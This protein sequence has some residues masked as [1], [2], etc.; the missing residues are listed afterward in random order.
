MT[1]FREPVEADWVQIGRLADAAV[2]HI[3]GAPCQG[4][5]VANRRAF[6]GARRHLVLEDEG[7]IVG[8]GAIELNAT[9]V[10]ARLFLV[11]AW[12][13][14]ESVTNANSLYEQ[15]R[16]EAA[17]MK[18]DDV[19]MREYAVDAPFVDFLIAHGFQIRREYEHDGMGVIELVRQRFATA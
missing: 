5:W 14:P 16:L 13:R 18:V 7:Q 15:L 9:S 12:R 2:Q 1:T 8:Y 19:W 6:S 10:V 3:P 4:A 11:L 17:N